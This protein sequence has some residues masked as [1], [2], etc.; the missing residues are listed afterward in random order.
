[1]GTFLSIEHTDTRRLR[2]WNQSPHTMKFATLSAVF[3]LIAS[4]SPAAGLSRLRTHDAT[5]YICC[6]SEYNGSASFGRYVKSAAG[7]CFQGHG[8]LAACHECHGLTLK[9]STIARD[10]ATSKGPCVIA[11][12][13]A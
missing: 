13:T 2:T 7:A 12:S 5:E 4:I 11:Q 9:P 10:P 1:M 6:K 3:A 8:R